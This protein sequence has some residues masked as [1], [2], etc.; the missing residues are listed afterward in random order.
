M[1][2]CTQCKEE[3]TKDQFYRNSQYKDE[4][5]PHCKGCKSKKDRARY[6]RKKDEICKSQRERYKENAE[7]YREKARNR[8]HK[9]MSDP[10]E[11]ARIATIKNRWS[12]ERARTD[13]SY[14]I[15]R[16]MSREVSRQIS[17]GG[18]GWNELLG[19]TLND[20]M[21]HLECQ[22]NEKM[23]WQNYG[24]YWHIDHIVPKSKFEIKEFGD[25]EFL[26]C[27]SLSNLRPLPAI[28]NLKKYN[29]ME[30][31]L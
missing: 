10:E 18:R 21:I 9:R 8:Y 1:K 26:E 22:F 27:W 31:I 6:L 29:K 25:P 17:K 14:R 16:S 30:C 20:L 7:I 11:R 2:T 12:K 23:S 13:P 5:H 4:L 24:S 3:L 19:Y 28:M 15:N